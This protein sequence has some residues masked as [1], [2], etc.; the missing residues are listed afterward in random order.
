M[1]AY[2]TKTQQDNLTESS[3]KIKVFAQ[4]A[5]HAEESLPDIVFN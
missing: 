3:E 1:C 2:L 5:N 4:T